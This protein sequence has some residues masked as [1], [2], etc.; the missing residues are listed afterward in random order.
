VILLGNHELFS[1][2][3]EKFR[4]TH[5][6]IIL[7]VAGALILILTVLLF[8]STFTT[9]LFG[10]VAEDKKIWIELSFLLLAALLG[11]M[12]IYYIK[13]PFVMILI[14]VG[15]LI[16]PSFIHLVWPY[17][18]E[19]NNALFSFALPTNP[20]EFIRVDNIIDFF[21]RL[22][23]IILL[24]TI[25]MHSS[26]KDIFNVKNFVVGLF[27]IILP[28]I[29]GYLYAMSTTGNFA[30]AMFVGAALTATSVAISVA[31]LK[32]I[33]LLDAEFSKIIIGAAV[34]DDVLALLVLSF[35]MSA[36]GLNAH[37]DIVKGTITLL[38][39]AFLFI[40]GG[41]SIGKIIVEKFID[42][43]DETVSRRMF[44]TIMAFVFTYV[45]IAE[46]IG[47]SAVVGAFLAGVILTYS[48][49]VDK[50]A[51]LLFPLEALFT[52]IFFITL[53]TMV[54]LPAVAKNIIPIA[55]ITL[56]AI[57]TKA[58]GCIAGALITGSKKLD[59]LIV[60]IGM[61]PRG[62]IAFIIALVGITNK[63][64]TP[65]Q[66]TVIVAVGFLTTI[67][68]IPVFQMVLAKVSSIS[69]AGQSI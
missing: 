46:F 45:Y 53:G 26:I 63:I 65:D 57:V 59:S 40:V 24:F 6:K 36:T 14:I 39:S 31:I 9:T 30:Y 61:V 42:T 10:S 51:K 1:E 2:A 5:G 68:Q 67:V 20:P 17:L 62:E 19:I 50:I 66:Y 44:T 8:I 55:A 18:V 52:P 21:S 11:E 47:L 37:A 48:K 43:M 15:V 58:V 34:V 23:A 13:Q 27:G 7:P 69:R 33:N 28:F 64:L 12:L 3:V 54:D 49:H 32:E 38:A 16:S 25:G 60:G 35:V 41:I 29:V 4:A 56:I 22:G